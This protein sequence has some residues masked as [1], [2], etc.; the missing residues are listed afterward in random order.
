[1]TALFPLCSIEQQSFLSKHY[2]N[3]HTLNLDELKKNRLGDDKN[4]FRILF[5]NEIKL[6]YLEFCNH[7]ITN[8]RRV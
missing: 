3:K 6:G 2:E 4:H 1:M 7:I 5:E 8:D